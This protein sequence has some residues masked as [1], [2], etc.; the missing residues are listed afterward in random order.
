MPEGGTVLDVGCGGGIAAFALTPPAAHVIGVDHQSAMLR[1]FEQNAAQRAVACETF[2]GFWPGVA[3]ATPRADVVTAHHVA[4][5]VADVVPFL[6][7]LSEHAEYRV[8]LELPDHHPLTSMTDA[9]RY[10]WQLERP[11]SPTPS[12]LVAVLEEMGRDVHA[13]QWSS[14]VRTTANLEQ[15][16]HFMRIRLCLPAAREA[17]VL[18]YFTAQPAVTRRDLTTLWW[19]TS[20][21]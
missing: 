1:M 8:V 9:W 13:E 15:A 3:A 14:P 2:E 10:F 6:R 17:E 16:A 18:D 21:S 11:T 5:N 19:D 4:Y 7:A 12:D 20:P